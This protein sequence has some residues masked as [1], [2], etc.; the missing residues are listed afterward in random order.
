[1]SALGSRAREAY[2]AR[3]ARKP[4]R[5]TAGLLEQATEVCGV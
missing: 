2:T 3:K 4:R 1:M 5:T